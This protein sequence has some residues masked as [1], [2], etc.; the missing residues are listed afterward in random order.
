[1]AYWENKKFDIDNASLQKLADY[2]NVST[3]YILCLTS[4]PTS[5]D[6]KEK[7][8]PDLHGLDPDKDRAY[9]SIMAD[10]KGQGLL[11]HDLKVIAE[12]YKA[13]KE[14]DKELKG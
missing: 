13:A 1:M 5:P 4:D 7:A 9:F 11:P 3:D 12:T 14:R 6:K 10:L 8:M 2:F